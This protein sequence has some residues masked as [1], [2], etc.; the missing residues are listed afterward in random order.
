MILDI[1]HNWL[2]EQG[3]MDEVL[4]I[5]QDT[6]SF[7]NNYHAFA[8]YLAPDE[9]T[10]RAVNYSTQTNSPSHL[11]DLNDPDF[12]EKLRAYITS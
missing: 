9:I 10:L 11:I 7:I 6:I 1:I 12:Q 4:H 3:L 5:D 2:K 8:I